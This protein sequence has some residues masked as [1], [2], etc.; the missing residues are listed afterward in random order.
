VD[1]ALKDAC[2]DLFGIACTNYAYVM[3]L[4]EISSSSNQWSV[5]FARAAHD[6]KVDVF[7][8][9]F[10]VL[11]YVRV[12]QECENK[13]WWVSIQKRVVRY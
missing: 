5:S 6:W 7:T 12:R 2:L 13:L 4:L 1:T 11:Y 3:A 9:F 10:R 8:S